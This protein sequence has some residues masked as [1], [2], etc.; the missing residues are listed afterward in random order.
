MRIAFLSAILFSACT[1]GQ[2]THYIAASGSDANNGTSQ[3]TPWAH[4]PGMQTCAASCATYTPHPGDQLILR[5][6][7]TWTNSNFPMTFAW[8]GSSGSPIYIGVNQTWYSGA[9][10]SRPIFNAGGSAISG[11][12]IFINLTGSPSYITI[13]NIEFT[14]MYWAGV[15]PYGHVVMLNAG[16]ATN[17]TVEN[18]YFHGWS[19]QL[20]GGTAN[21]NGTAMTW[22]SGTMFNPAWTTITLPYINGGMADIPITVN[23][24]TSITLSSAPA[25]NPYTNVMFVYTDDNI[26]A[27][28]GETNGNFNS[29]SVFQYNVCDGSDT[30]TSEGYS[31]YCVHYFPTSL[32][33]VIHDMSNGHLIS[34][35]GGAI[36][37]TIYNINLSFSGQHENAIES[38]VGGTNYIA[39]NLIHDTNAETAFLG[40][41]TPTE[42]DYVWNNVAYNVSVGFHLEGRNANWTG[43]YVNNT[44]IVPSGLYCFIQAGS[45]A[46]LT[47]LLEN[48]HCMTTG[49]LANESYT[50]VTNLV[51]TPTAAAAQGYTSSETYAYSPANG[52][53]ST[54]GTGTN[55]SSLAT[56]SVASLAMDALYGCTQ[57]ATNHVVCPARSAI[58]RPGSGAWNMGAYMFGNGTVPVPPTG[59]TAVSQ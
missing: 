4:V 10:W 6:G 2:V 50:L 33:N 17:L 23:S 45:G 46:T 19:Y 20:D 56:G 3:A 53:G 44:I 52:S 59:L 40:G 32:S 14:G 11:P 28:Q 37:N 51:Q 13:D 27:I 1:W 42:T 36:G 35:N 18:C 7:D 16:G 47:V 12:N 21:I 9:S 8:S 22:V 31:G 24:T 58:S 41:G 43:Y 5:G 15:T 38:T 55:A 29:G 30:I 39:N 54:V 34:A 48:N 57:D 49:S 25:G 26:G